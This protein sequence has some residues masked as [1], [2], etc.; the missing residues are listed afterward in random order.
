MRT[1]GTAAPL[2]SSTVPERCATDGSDCA[3][4]EKLTANIRKARK[5]ERRIV[6]FIFVLR[7]RTRWELE[8]WPGGDCIARSANF[9]GLLAWRM[10]SAPG[11]GAFARPSRDDASSSSVLPQ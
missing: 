9:A 6:G 2:E 10:N 7:S 3:C 8:G 1:P 4:E 11:C 5:A